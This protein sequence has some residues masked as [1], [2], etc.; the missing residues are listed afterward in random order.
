VFVETFDW[1]ENKSISNSYI[2]EATKRNREHLDTCSQ[3][4]SISPSVSAVEKKVKLRKKLRYVRKCIYHPEST[5]GSLFESLPD[6]LIQRIFT[7][8][9]WEDLIRLSEVCSR[10]NGISCDDFLWEFHCKY[11]GMMKESELCKDLFDGSTVMWR[12]S[13]IRKQKAMRRERKKREFENFLA[14]RLDDEVCFSVCRYCNVKRA[15]S[16]TYQRNVRYITMMECQN[17]RRTWEWNMSMFL[18]Q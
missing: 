6:E 3:S 4:L 10:F 7:Y 18:I 12:V 15:R 16:V 8:V 5:E 13:F 17:C 1:M 2:H 9:R 11:C 14:Q